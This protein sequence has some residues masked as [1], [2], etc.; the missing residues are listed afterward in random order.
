MNYK[1]LKTGDLCVPYVVVENFGEGLG[2]EEMRA[3]YK[4]ELFEL[5]EKLDTYMKETVRMKK[6]QAEREG[7]AFYD[8]PLVRL[9]NVR[10]DGNRVLIELQRTS[11]HRF[12]CSNRSLDKKLGGK[13]IRE[14]YVNE[15]DLK[16]LKDGLANPI[17]VNLG[18]V[19]SDNHVI[20]TKRSK[21]L[22]QY[23]GLY[24]VPAGFMQPE[25]RYDDK[26]Y[27]VFPVKTPDVSPF[28][29]AVRELWEEVNISDSTIPE[30]MKLIEIGRVYDDL[31]AEII[32]HTRTDAKSKDVR[33][34]AKFAV[35]KFEGPPILAEF[36]PR[37]LSKYMV[38]TIKERPLGTPDIQ[39]IWIPEKSPQ[40][41][42][43]HWRTVYLLLEKEY[44]A[45]EIER[46]LKK[47]ME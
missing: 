2:T 14:L 32:M 5:P 31:H 33:E 12:A 19:T 35:D 6:E 3:S 1:G 45:K 47:A 18:I 42:P 7:K 34:Q 40:W 36:N 24:G 28:I 13:T 39:G 15:N 44:G 8:G 23:P 11:Y 22:H 37:A 10:K 9:G 41:V 16:N 29:T 30:N 26:K 21:K 25:D 38:E 46:E 27:G 4:D 17:G 43:A 20:L